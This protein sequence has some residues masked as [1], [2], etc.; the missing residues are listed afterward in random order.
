LQ[1]IQI[2][3]LFIGKPLVY[4]PTCH[5]TNTVAQEISQNDSFFEGTLVITDHQTAGRGQ[6]GNVWKSVAGQN[7]TFSLLLKPKF[8]KAGEQFNLNMAIS[9]GIAN[10]LANH[11]GNE[12][13]KVKWPNDILYKNSKICGILIENTIKQGHIEKSIV[14]IGINVNQTDFE[15]DRAISMQLISGL[16]YSL[17]KLL[18][19]LLEFIEEQY[20]LLLQGNSEKIRQHY[21]NTLFKYGEMNTYKTPEGLMEGEIIGI[22]PIGRIAIRFDQELRYFNFKEVE[23]Y[24]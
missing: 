15:Y 7:F 3:T 14:G 4:L 2:N 16:T 24:Y 6:Q 10:F 12:S 17:E 23:F 8:L 19:E 5:S 13:V 11:L 22:D 20:L 1:N 18:P 21:L 9:L